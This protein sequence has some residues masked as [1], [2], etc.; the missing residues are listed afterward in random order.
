MFCM[1]L[2]LPLIAGLWS[3]A[4]TAQDASHPD[5]TGTFR[6]T[7]RTATEAKVPVIGTTIVKTTSKLLATVTWTGG[8]YVQ[9]H[10]T[11]TV[12]AIPS[13]G[14][15]KTVLPPTFI[16]ALPVKTYPLRLSQDAQ[17]WA[18]DA[19]LMPQSVGYH[20]D[21]NGGV[22]PKDKDN[23]AIYDWDEDGK[24]GASVMVDIPVIGQF[25]IYMVQ[26]SHARLTGR[27]QSADLVTGKTVMMALDQK[28]IGADNV[29]F[30]SSP[31]VAPAQGHWAFEM[32]R[33]ADGSTCSD[34]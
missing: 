27:V 32:E 2:V 26:F 24:P 13:R 18:F 22:M 34:L 20:P 16:A 5:L 28:T 30:S 33:I 15:A 14:I 1:R 21:Q 3:S 4:A 8:Q 17:G 11:C 31:S 9:T 6:L 10:R 23:P 12:D 7:M 19:D 29:L 25:R